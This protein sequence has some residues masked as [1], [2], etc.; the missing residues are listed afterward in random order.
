MRTTS[1]SCAQQRSGRS[2]SADCRCT[3]GDDP[4]RATGPRPTRPSDRLTSLT[5]AAAVGDVTITVGTVAGLAADQAI[6]IGTVG[7]A[8]TEGRKITAVNAA[9]NQVDIDPALSN[10]HLVGT[11]V[12]QARSPT[13]A[14]LVERPTPR[15]C[16]P[17]R[18]RSCCPR[19]RTCG[20]TRCATSCATPPRR[21]TQ[22]I[23]RRRRISTWRTAGGATAAGASRLTWATPD[24]S[25][26]GSTD[27]GHR[28]R[29]GG[30]PRGVRVVPGRQQQ[31][32]VVGCA[33]VA[34]V[35]NYSTMQLA[36]ANNNLYLLGRSNGGVDTWRFDT[37]TSTWSRVGNNNP[38]WSDARGGPTWP[39][40]PRCSWRWPTTICTCWAVVMVGSIPGGSTPAPRRGP[41]RQQ[42]PAMVGCAG[43]AD[44]ANYSTMQLAVA[45]NDLY[46]LGRSNGGVDTWRFDT[47]TST[48]SR[49]GNNNPP[50]S[51]AL[52]WADVANYSTMQLAVEA[53]NNLYLLARGD[54]GVDTWRFDTGTSTW[55]QVGNN[56]PP[57][58][59]AL[60][61][62]DVANYS[63]MQLAVANN[64]LYLLARGDAGVDTWRFDTGTSTWSQVGNNNPP[65]SDALGWADVANYS[66]MQL[67]VANNNLYLLARGDAGVD[68]WR[69]DTGTSTWTQVGNNNPPWSDALGWADVAN[70]STMQL[71]VANNNL[72]LLARGNVGS[73]PGS[74]TPM[75]SR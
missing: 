8:G 11:D 69:F 44:V 73:I 65:W 22:T 40:T 61:W 27:S 21:S 19:T 43:W 32:A 10:T 57:W 56:N 48:W 26:A 24:R 31:P 66:T 38:P 34:D 75:H 51:D 41:G 67:A 29:R 72:Y 15:L 59:D 23:P 68:T 70:Y 30:P 47:G 2:R 12:P 1:T 42:Q 55:S 54:A 6:L 35:T 62:A 52:G 45:N 36:V 18:A 74:P 39:T 17:A 53:N 7:T 28:R 9:A 3:H 71:A 50:W 37:G 33:G 60:G 16:A 25:S 14:T 4:D 20:G 64:N 46:L 5:A 13:A 58:S 49:V 63:T